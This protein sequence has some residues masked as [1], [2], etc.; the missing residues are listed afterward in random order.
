[1]P[2]LMAKYTKSKSFRMGKALFHRLSAIADSADMTD[3]EA[4]RALLNYAI[5]Q[6]ERGELDDETLREIEGVGEYAE[7]E[8]KD[9]RQDRWR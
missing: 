4:I 7:D 2:R 1:M 8:D 6:Y 3:T 5:T 9:R